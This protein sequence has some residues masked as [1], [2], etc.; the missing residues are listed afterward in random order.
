MSRPCASCGG[1]G[2]VIADP[3]SNCRGTGAEVR[4]R[5]VKVRIPAG[6]KS[7]QKIRLKGR[8]GPGRFGGPAGDLFVTIKVNAH[9]VFG[10]SGKDLTLDLPI[11]FAEAALGA[12]V[13]VPTLSG[14]S[15]RMKVPAGTPSGKTFR[16]R[17]KGGTGDLLVTAQI[18]VPDDL[19]PEQRQA[20][21]AFAAATE[22][23]PRDQL[24]T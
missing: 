22:S 3:C 2:T 15:V 7:G 10:R 23:S 1:R 9:P 18:V 16:L 12:Q 8:G 11:T 14:P 4:P 20:V 24:T 21:E 13:D 5:E 19:T 6:V 17:D